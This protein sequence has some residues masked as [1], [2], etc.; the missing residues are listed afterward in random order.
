MDDL[1]FMSS[2]ISLIERCIKELLSIFDGTHGG[3]ISWYLG[4]S[5]TVYPDQIV[6]S[7]KTYIDFLLMEYNMTN[8]NNVDT[9]IISSFYADIS[10]ISTTEVLE[11]SLYRN[12]VRSL[13]YI[14]NRTRPDIMT[15]VRILKQFVSAPNNYLWKAALR[16]LRYPCGTREYVLVF[17]R[18]SEYRLQGYVHADFGQHTVNRKSRTGFMLRIRN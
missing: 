3:D 12:L 1:I 8:S 9:P 10:T 16:V 13:L 2:N 7:R 4:I 11:G 17:N 6:L 14:A 15:A 18:C 5:I